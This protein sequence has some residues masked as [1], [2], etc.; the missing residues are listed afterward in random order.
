M[1]YRKDY[2]W[3]NGDLGDKLMEIGSYV[4]LLG[5][6]L[7]NTLN[8]RVEKY[9]EAKYSENNFYSEINKFRERSLAKESYHAFTSLL[10]SIF[11]LQHFLHNG[12][13][14]HMKKIE[15]PSSLENVIKVI[16]VNKNSEKTFNYENYFS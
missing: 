13:K 11:L 15:G 2:V 4:P 14:R 9:I 5:L 6:P 3:K 16:G 7:D 12:P 8:K 10:I 1:N